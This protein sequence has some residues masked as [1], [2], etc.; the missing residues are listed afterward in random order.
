MNHNHVKVLKCRYVHIIVLID[1]ASKCGKFDI[2][3]LLFQDLTDKGL[4][5]NVRTYSVMIIALC[6]EG[7]V[8]DA[9][10][11]FLMMEESGCPPNN[12]TYNVLLQGYLK[13]QY[14]DDLG[15]LLHEMDGRRYSLDATTLSLFLDQIAAGLLHNTLLDLIGKLVPKELVGASSFS[16]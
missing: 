16:T 1:G 10:D 2:A 15:I 5:P 9:K 4:C 6:R 13:N 11:L 12:V 7:L 14:Y 3:R 8:R